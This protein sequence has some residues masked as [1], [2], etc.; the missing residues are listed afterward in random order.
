MKVQI[1]GGDVREGVQHIN[2]RSDGSVVL[3]YSGRKETLEPDA[4]FDVSPE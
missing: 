4:G 2:A 1:H 3:R